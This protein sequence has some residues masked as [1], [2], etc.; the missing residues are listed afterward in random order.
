M[1]SDAEKPLIESIPDKITQVT[2]IGS[3]TAA[4]NWP[5]LRVTD[6]SGYVTMTSS[7]NPGD[8]FL[9]GSTTVTY[10]AFDSSENTKTVKFTVTVMGTLRRYLV[11]MKL[12][13][14]Y[15]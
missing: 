6:N 5:A 3:P 8:S 10:T 9:L 13:P 2:D 12:K 15:L 1:Y 4:V 7:H 11:L 14:L